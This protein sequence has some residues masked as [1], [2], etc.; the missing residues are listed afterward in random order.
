MRSLKNE[1][2]NTKHYFKLLEL[3]LLVINT[4]YKK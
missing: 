1:N 4:N 3:D 2:H